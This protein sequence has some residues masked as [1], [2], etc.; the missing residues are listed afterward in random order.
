ML[1]SV[2]TSVPPVVFLFPNF[3]L[4][5][6]LVFHLDSLP[7]WLCT[8]VCC[9]KALRPDSHLHSGSPNLHTHSRVLFFFLSA[10]RRIWMVDP[11]GSHPHHCMG[12]RLQHP[13]HGKPGAKCQLGFVPAV[14]GALNL[15]IQ[16]VLGMREAPACTFCMG[17]AG[18]LQLC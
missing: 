4:P 5:K 13:L 18:K 16:E 14:S 17:A 2:L 9:L 12:L 3:W 6:S 1:A 10:G 7:L 11:G 15:L 8:A